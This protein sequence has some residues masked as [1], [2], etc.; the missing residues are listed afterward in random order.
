[1]HN[2]IISVDERIGD[3]GADKLVALVKEKQQSIRFP[4]FDNLGLS[5]AKL[6]ELLG[7]FQDCPNVQ[8]FGLNRTTFEMESFEALI[9]LL[10]SCPKIYEF[11]V[12]DCKLNLE[13][14]L[15]LLKAAAAH[16]GSG[17]PLELHLLRNDFSDEDAEKI[18]KAYEDCG[19][20]FT[21]RFSG[22]RMTF[23]GVDSHGDLVNQMGLDLAPWHCK[24]QIDAL[25]KSDTVHL[26]D[27]DVARVDSLAAFI[28]DDDRVKDLRL[29]VA[30]QDDGA[31]LIAEALKTNKTITKLELK[32]A[33]IGDEGA[34]A[35]AEALSVNTAIE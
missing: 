25:M 17:A 15:E 24:A 5:E 32:H 22:T 10:E 11:S 20:G 23:E 12:D 27:G 6:C 16:A 26:S 4:S 29:T 30:L 1:M 2:A 31:A 19:K 9:H 7:A 3:S 14:A 35:I 28:K 33:E 13:Q 34:K 18:V 8:I 21:L